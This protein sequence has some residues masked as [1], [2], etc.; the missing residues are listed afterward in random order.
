MFS[1]TGHTLGLCVSD[2]VM[3]IVACKW[4]IGMY[5]WVVLIFGLYFCSTGC[6]F[7]NQSV[8]VH[9]R[10]IHWVKKNVV[11]SSDLLLLFYKNERLS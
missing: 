8:N 4:E 2:D 5:S 7:K 11:Q 10:Y 1:V 6:S 3:W 9:F